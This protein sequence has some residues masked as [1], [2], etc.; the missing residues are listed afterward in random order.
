MKVA[1]ATTDG[2]NLQTGHFGHS[3]IYRIFDFDGTDF[4][5]LESI[6]NPL[7]KIHQHAKVSDVLQ[8]LSDCKVWA[9]RAMGN[10][11]K[12]YLEKNNYVPVIL[13]T[14]NVSDA[15]LEIKP[16]LKKKLL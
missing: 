5:S 13:K 15:L 9:G 8:Y 1:I 7:A 12:K 6:E 4:K 14:N 11:S 16:I 2:E 10:K 3:A